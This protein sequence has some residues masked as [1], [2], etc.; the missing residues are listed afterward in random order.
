MKNSRS[1]EIGTGRVRAAGIRRAGFSHHAVPGSKLAVMGDSGGYAVTA[2]FDN[3]G[4]YPGGRTGIAMGG[5]KIAGRKGRVRLHRLQGGG[6]NGHR[7][8]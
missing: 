1:L 5:V 7:Q 4:R 6:I 8:T 2:R 3:G